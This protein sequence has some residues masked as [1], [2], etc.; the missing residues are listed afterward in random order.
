MRIIILNILLLLAFLSGNAQNYSV[1]ESKAG[2]IFVFT[3]YIT[4]ENESNF[5]DFRIG[6]YGDEPVITKTLKAIAAKNKRKGKKIE[7]VNFRS[8]SNLKKVHLIYVSNKNN[9]DFDNIV[10]KLGKQNVLYISDNYDINKSM[11]NFIHG[12]LK[13]SFEVNDRNI[14]EAG[15]LSSSRLADFSKTKTN[16]QELYAK[17]DKKL[18]SE[19]QKVEKQK[20]ML[21]EQEDKIDQQIKTLERQQEAIDEQKEEMKRQASILAEQQKEMNAQQNKIDEQK[22]VLDEQSARIKAQRMVLFLFILIILLVLVF[23]YFIYRGYKQKQK[24]NEELTQ[25]NEEIRKQSQEIDRQRRLLEESNIQLEKL[26]IVAR[27]TENAVVIAHLDGTIE[28]INEGFNH[29]YGYTYKTLIEEKGDNLFEIS[30]NP[31]IRKDLEKCIENKTSV[32]FVARNYKRSGEEIWVQTT[33]T[34]IY[35]EQGDLTKLVAIDTN[36]TLLKEAEEEILQQKEEIEKSLNMIKVQ[37]VELSKA[38]EQISEQKDE[39]EEAYEKVQETTRL[40]EI[41]LANT[42]HE[43]RTPLN[44]IMGFTGLLLKTSLTEKQLEQL[45]YIKS[46]GANLLVIINDILDFSKIEA[47]KL[48]IERISFDLRHFLNTCIR[49]LAVKSEE[50]N[51]DL[52]Y[53]IDSDI[54]D[55]LVGDPTRLNQIITNLVGNS[56]KFTPENGQITVDIELQD[57]Y[58]NSVKLLFKVTDT[59]IGIDKEKL[60]NIF[61]SF[62]Q[63]ESSTTRKYGGT[64]LG[65]SIVKKLVE[66]QEGTISVESKLNKGTCFF[67]ELT[68]EIG[69]ADDIDDS[70]QYDTHLYDCHPSNISILLVEDNFV[71]RQLAADTL[72]TWETDKNISVDYAENGKQAVE[73]AEAKKYNIIL[74]DYQMPVMDGYRATGIIR[75]NKAGL[76]AE[77]P[78]VAMTANAAENE[79]EKCLDIGMQ[80]Y[81]TKP[82][83]PDELYY[84]IKIYTCKDYSFGVEKHIELVCDRCGEKAKTDTKSSNP[85]SKQKKLAGKVEI[86]EDKIDLKHFEKIYKGNTKKINLMLKMY[87]QKTPEEIKEL[88]QLYKE[89]DWEAFKTNAHALK[90]KML[91]I[92]LKKTSQICKNLEFIGKDKDGFERIPNLLSGLESSWNKA[93]VEIENL[94]K[95]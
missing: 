66:L 73:M 43:I 75:G 8:L 50:K 10:S 27:E 20:E 32:D 46:A 14:V 91:Y 26:S 13:K 21:K 57:K 92:G 51:I 6:I 56:V 1:E 55:Y 48:T 31:N 25:T 36:I 69:N 15:M 5:D 3:K 53:N 80:D 4:W 39:L 59:G 95:T 65:L 70:S 40:K 79:R 89:E 30:S 61:D 54:P 18:K 86:L 58:E 29:F 76:N 62:T 41:F 72:D 35:D 9:K 88:F 11:I 17:S 63:A 49:T 23:S 87:L 7:V 84:K 34:P 94:I 45:E 44:A 24:I 42:S 77:T 78:I 60:E 85:K 74:M 16:W 12:N 93:S 33:L 81:I 64:G 2:F 82:F 90:P 37:Q 68:F 28:W 19:M 83:N 67:F 22:T 71:N 47:G 52:E 38:F